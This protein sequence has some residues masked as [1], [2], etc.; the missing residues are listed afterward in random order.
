VELLADPGTGLA[1][2]ALTSGHLCPASN[3]P[4]P[5]AQEDYEDYIET[6]RPRQSMQG[7]RMERAVAEGHQQTEA[8]FNWTT[9]P[10]AVHTKNMT[11]C[12]GR[13]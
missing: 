8:L 7:S 2:A 3:W 10:G 12:P 5:L 9:S 4:P 6:T 1:R 13:T 11:F